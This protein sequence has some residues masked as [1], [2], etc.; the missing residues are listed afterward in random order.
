VSV[1]AAGPPVVRRIAELR[2]ALSA[3]RKAGEGIG[4]IP[5]MGALHEGH[6]ALVRQAK[7]EGPRAVATLFVNPTQFGA[8][9][10]LASY[11]RD[12]AGD[13]ALLGRAGADLLFAPSVDEVYPAGFATTVSVARLTDHLCG[14]HRPGHFAGVATVVAKLLNQALPERAY[15]G[16]K[17][18][19]QLQVIRRMARDLDI[20]VAIRGVPTVR[21]ADGLALSSRNV[22]LSAD[23]R[24]RA[25]TLPRLLRA[26]AKLLAEGSPAP[27][28][29]EKVRRGL[30]EAGFQK[31]DYVTLADEAELQPL[32]TP[33][34]ACRL[35]AAAWIGRT[36]LIDNWRVA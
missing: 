3:W 30:A 6:L 5:T 28:E 33:T 16:E 26:A 13:R 24:R 9:E 8:N 14:P 29:I 10:D 7:S 21:E 12:E 27:P 15:F 36:R 23:E 32:D 25:A 1:S 2:T 20:P 22:Y 19:Q 35:F 4:L 18:F 34:P 31:I 17:D 11:P